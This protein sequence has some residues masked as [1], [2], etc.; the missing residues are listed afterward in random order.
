MEHLAVIVA[1]PILTFL[2]NYLFYRFIKTDV[3]NKIH[4]NNISYSGVFREKIDIYREL[5]E[6]TYDIHLILV[7][8]SLNG[9]K[10]D[11]KTTILLLHEYKRFYSVNR[12]YLSEV[13][14]NHFIKLFEEYKGIWEKLY[15]YNSQNNTDGF[16]EFLNASKTLTATN[17]FSQ[18]EKQLIE[19]MKVEL[20]TV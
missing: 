13:V 4:Q 9:T 7:K 2:F 20:K 5:L 6:K 10:E 3:E 14:L 17:L 11:G 1:T 18:I 16:S 12:P 8:M 15:K 19:E